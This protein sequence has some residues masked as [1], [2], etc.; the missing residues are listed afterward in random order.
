MYDWEKLNA[1]GLRQDAV[2]EDE[3]MS[4]MTPEQQKKLKE[5]L[6][7]KM[8]TVVVEPP[9]PAA[10]Q[11]QA[12]LSRLPVSFGFKDP[13]QAALEADLRDKYKKLNL[14]IEQGIE[15]Q[16]QTIDDYKR[17]SPNI[18]FS[19]MAALADKWSGGG[20]QLSQAASAIR[21]PTASEKL[22]QLMKMQGQT[23]DDEKALLSELGS[24]MAAKDQMKMMNSMMQNQRM[25]AGQDFKM[26]GDFNK[27][28]REDV[29]PYYEIM[30]SYGTVQAA[31]TPDAQGNINVQRLHQALSNASRLLGEKGVLTDQDIARVQQP[32][33]DMYAAKLSGLAG[34]PSATIPAAQVAPLIRAIQEGSASWQNSLQRKLSATG[35]TAKAMGLNPQF[36][37]HVTKTIY[38]DFTKPQMPAQPV[39]PVQ[40]A[41][42]MDI[43]ELLKGK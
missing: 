29:K 24:R 35:E 15:K 31:L 9:T 16:N 6:E 7:K 23:Q 27:Q 4:A 1:L 36:A 34:D 37:D 14:G 21:G 41:G 17:V 43:A 39:Q 42:G 22:V 33:L 2:K 8:G 28:V 13:E 26:A 40:P 38:G 11:P 3:L 19:P 20:N 30:P 12:M 10:Q 32:T 25:L 5:Q 18:D